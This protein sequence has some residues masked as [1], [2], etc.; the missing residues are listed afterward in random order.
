MPDLHRAGVF[1]LISWQE[2]GEGEKK[3]GL[4][5]PTDE[6]HLMST[7]VCYLSLLFIHVKFELSSPRPNNKII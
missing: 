7:P 5:A 2:E 3:K 4:K 1:G 6:S